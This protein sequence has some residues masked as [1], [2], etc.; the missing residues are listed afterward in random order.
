[1][2][3]PTI[4]KVSFSYHT[5]KVMVVDLPAQGLQAEKVF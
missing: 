4:I 1:M 5:F 3:T 2:G